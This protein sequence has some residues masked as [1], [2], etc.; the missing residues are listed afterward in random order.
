[1]KKRKYLI[2]LL[3]SIIS[4]FFIAYMLVAVQH[5]F[6]KKSIMAEVIKNEYN[7]DLLLNEIEEIKED[8]CIV[9]NSANVENDEYLRE[10]FVNHNLKEIHIQISTDK[11]LQRDGTF[12]FFMKEGNQQ[13][14]AVT[15]YGFYYTKFNKP[16]GFEGIIPYNE[17]KNI[18][19]WFGLHY[20]YHTEP[21]KDN[22]WYYEMK[23]YGVSL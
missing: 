2:V 7:L 4:L 22:W 11:N 14:K 17:E 13:F 5:F 16:I 18:S 1:M 19:S 9:I 12:I 3:T 21:I 20:K 10:L 6:I 8:T 23:M 15:Y